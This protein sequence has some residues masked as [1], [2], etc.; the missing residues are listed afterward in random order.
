M[1]IG[2]LVP[3]ILGSQMEKQGYIKTLCALGVVVFLI[4]LFQIALS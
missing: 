2:Y 1:T 3:G 4:K